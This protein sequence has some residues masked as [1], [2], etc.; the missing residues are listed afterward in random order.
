MTAE[1]AR[2]PFPHDYLRGWFLPE[3]EGSDAAKNNVD[4]LERGNDD[5]ALCGMGVRVN[6]DFQT[7]PQTEDHIGEVS[8][9]QIT[10]YDLIRDFRPVPVDAVSRFNRNKAQQ[11]FYRPG[12]QCRVSFARSG[13]YRSFH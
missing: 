2:R 10:G 7:A 13:L 11:A 8:E 6:D 4:V 12:D 3:R 5:T 9:E 1:R